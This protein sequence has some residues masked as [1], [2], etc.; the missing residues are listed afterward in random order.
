MSTVLCISSQ[1]VRGYVGGSAARIALERMGHDCWLLP[2]VILSNHPGHTRFAG[3]Q[4]PVGRLRAM[5]EALDA[6]GWVEEVDAVLIG[7]MPSPE[8]VA[9]A[10]QAIET[11]KKRNPDALCLCDPILG[12]DPAGLY[13]DPDTAAAVREDFLP[14][15][16]ILTPNR[17]ELEWLSGVSAKRAKTAAA[18]ALDLAPKTVLVTSLTGKDVSS[19]VNLL[20]EEGTLAVTTVPKRKHAPHGPGDLMAALFLGNLLSGES[21][22]DAL[23]KATGGVEVALETSEKA[24]ELRLVS[25]PDWADAEPWPVEEP[26]SK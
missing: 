19:L 24:D 23:A 17:F 7:Y 1:V 10:A 2:T 9:F 18:A 6:N 20:V 16:D 21:A 3:E 26:T 8:H 11:V 25:M 14:L 5:L 4:V 13:L 15:A 22:E 12:D